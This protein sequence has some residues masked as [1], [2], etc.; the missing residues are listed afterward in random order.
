MAENTIDLVQQAGFIFAGTVQELRASTIQHLSRDRCAVIQVNSTIDAPPIL[1][2]W[3]GRD[4]TIGL[5]TPEDV[6]VGESAIFFAGSWVY[7]EGLAL[8]E[9]GRWPLNQDISHVRRQIVEA[10][11]R[12]ADEDLHWRLRS[13]AIVVVGKVAQVADAAADEEGGPEREH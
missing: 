8:R 2:S 9:V 7:G 13:A 5:R 6:K 3:V 4:I 12:L 10:R 11:K 1:D